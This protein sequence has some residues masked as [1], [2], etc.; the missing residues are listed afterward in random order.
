M[1]DT[2]FELIFNISNVKY[3]IKCWKKIYRYFQFSLKSKR[4]LQVKF[5]EKQNTRH[6]CGS[7]KNKNMCDKRK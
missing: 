7:Y 4:I 2:F 1:K 6:F 3:V 5:S